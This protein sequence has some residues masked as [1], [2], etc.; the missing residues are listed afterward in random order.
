MFL[1]CFF[2]PVILQI[3]MFKGKW[4]TGVAKIEFF[5]IFFWLKGLAVWSF[6]FGLL[7]AV[8]SYLREK[9]QGLL[10]YHFKKIDTVTK[11]LENI[12]KRILY[13]EVTN[14]EIAVVCKNVIKLF[15]CHMV[16]SITHVATNH[17][18]RWGWIQTYAMLMNF[19]HHALGAVHMEVGWPYK[20]IMYLYE[21]CVS[22]PK[23]DPSWFFQD[24][25]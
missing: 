4:I 22:L 19:L 10:N 17:S 23:W 6:L 16:R 3:F 25:T 15:T 13:A 5:K 8:S 18:V 11:I 24:P 12:C 20:N 2:A 21:K 9:Q 14:I 1:E 7:I